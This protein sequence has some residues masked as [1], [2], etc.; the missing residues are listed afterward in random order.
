MKD[1]H[2][3]FDKY[4]IRPG[5]ATILDA[6]GAW[7][8]QAASNLV[9]IE[10][11]ADERGTN[12]YN[13]ALGERRAKA[14]MNYLVSQG[15][16]ASRMTIISYGEERPACTDKNESCWSKNRRAHFLVKAR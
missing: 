1:I 5:D 16:Q 14:T 4:D 12:E 11:H 3:D 15:I 8:K 13:L 7:L 9:L 6:N 2:F 10:G